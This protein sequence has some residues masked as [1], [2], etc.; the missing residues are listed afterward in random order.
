MS[1]ALLRNPAE[2]LFVRGRM[3]SRHQSNPRALRGDNAKLGHMP[4]DRIHSPTASL[5]VSRDLAL[6]AYQGGVTFDFSRPGKPTDNAFIE[7][8][9]G[10]LRAECLKAH[11]FM[12]LHDARRKY[13]ARRRDYNEE[14]P[15]RFGNKASVKLI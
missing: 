5:G 10:K 8:F 9:N 4:T 7:S 3:L 6:W 14:Q 11:W 13:E 2:P 12:S 15:H 1:I